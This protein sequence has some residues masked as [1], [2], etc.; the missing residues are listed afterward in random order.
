[1]LGSEAVVVRYEVR[2]VEDHK[3]PKGKDW[4][5]IRS[6]TECFVF[7]K[8]KAV[9]PSVLEETWAAYR[10]SQVPHSMSA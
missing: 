8:E 7:V 5:M 10:A 2:F 4:M 3:L 9:C 6:P 1:M